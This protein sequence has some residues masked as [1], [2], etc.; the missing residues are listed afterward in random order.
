MP[1][2]INTQIAV[3]GTGN[4]FSRPRAS[5]GARCHTRNTSGT[6]AARM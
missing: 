1:F 4:L 2:W 5:A 3:P 6:S